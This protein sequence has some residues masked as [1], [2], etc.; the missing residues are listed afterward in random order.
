MPFKSY[1]INFILNRLYLLYNISPRYLFNYFRYFTSPIPF[2]F[3]ILVLILI[4]TNYNHNYNL[5]N[6]N[7]S[8]CL[9]GS[10][11]VSY[12]P[13]ELEENLAPAFDDALTPAGP[14]MP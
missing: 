8:H 5:Y 11:D 6:P 2:R 10:P 1:Y 14:P 13:I 4:T 3:T 12:P 9:Y 7:P